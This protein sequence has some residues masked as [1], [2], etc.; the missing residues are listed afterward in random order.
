MDLSK[1]RIVKL[2]KYEASIIVSS[3]DFALQKH[4]KVN[5]DTA[6]RLRAAFA[7]LAKVFDFP[8]ERI[9]A[10]LAGGKVKK[11]KVAFTTEEMEQ[12][13][14]AWAERVKAGILAR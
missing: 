1:E 5:K 13:E 6:D 14:A 12:A 10:M 3:M 11:F 8:T 2:N 9:E 4:R 7:K